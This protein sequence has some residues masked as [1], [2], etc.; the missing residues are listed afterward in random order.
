MDKGSFALG[1]ALGKAKRAIAD[2]AAPEDEPPAVPE[3]PAADVRVEKPVQRIAEK[4]ADPAPAKK[5]KPKT[6]VLSDK[7]AAKKPAPKKKPAP[8]TG[9]KVA[10]AAG[11]QL[12]GLGK[13]FGSFKDEFDKASKGK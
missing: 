4:S 7:P 1:R 11:K 5:P 2:A 3:V 10:R 13:M 12:S 6:Y 9:D 8:S